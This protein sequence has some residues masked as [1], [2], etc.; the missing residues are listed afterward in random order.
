MNSYTLEEKYRLIKSKIKQSKSK[1][2][3]EIAK[4]IM[5]EDFVSIHG[6]EH[7]FLDGAAFLAALKNSGANIDL[8]KS[9][10]MLANRSIAMPGAM[11]G[12]WG[13]CGSV[14]SI[15]A[16][17][18]I[19]DQTG[20]LSNDKPYSE[21]MKFASSVIEKMSE[22]GGPRCCKRNAFI[23]IIN[24]VSYVKEHYGIEMELE[25]VECEFSPLN[26][27]CIKEKCP[28]NKIKKE[29]KND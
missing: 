10:E 21:H 24:G 17:L 12:Y 23:S 4:S 29:G 18:S 22:I 14:A 15:W 20:P 19:I 5:H 25:K 13:I 3:I 16:A 1:N 11:C 7:H 2:P 26:Q 8:D 27:Q 6:P 9:L 28:F